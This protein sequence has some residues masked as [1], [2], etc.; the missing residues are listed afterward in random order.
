MYKKFYLALLILLSTGSAFGMEDKSEPDCSDELSNFRFLEI[1]QN[2]YW[3]PKPLTS[4]LTIAFNPFNVMN[5]N[6]EVSSGDA[7]H[8][9]LTQLEKSANDLM[10]AEVPPTNE[11]LTQLLCDI[12]LQHELYGPLK[13]LLRYG[14]DPNCHNLLG[15]TALC[16]AI[17]Q[18]CLNNVKLLLKHKS[19]A[20]LKCIGFCN[21]TPLVTAMRYFGELKE[22][23]L[24]I[25][26]LLLQYGANANMKNSKGNTSLLRIIE[27][28]CNLTEELIAVLLKFGA[29]PKIENIEGKNAILMAREM[30]L[31]HLANLME[32]RVNSRTL[33][34]LCLKSIIMRQNLKPFKQSQFNVLPNDLKEKINK[35]I[36]GL[37]KSCAKCKIFAGNE[38]KLLLC[39]HCKKVYYCGQECQK[40]DWDKHKAKC[41]KKF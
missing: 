32:T 14:V 29:D 25:I 40:A 4:D 12:A 26:T 31:E 22:V 39:G 37:I 21:K 3:N 30:G 35:K 18:R 19:N 13:K 11:K 27:N 38:I 41:K 1:S 6:N 7:R 33:Q 2:A 24:E 10:I 9:Y 34:D 16:K 36:P 20:N 23:D 8:K 15:R 28:H 17:T 5:T